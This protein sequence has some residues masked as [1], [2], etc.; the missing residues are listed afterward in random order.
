MEQ[1]CQ[2]TVHKT[3]RELLSLA[4]QCNSMNDGS[5][6][7]LDSSDSFSITIQIQIRKRCEL[8]DARNTSD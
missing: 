7:H 5:A 8:P 4:L 1:L 6:C 2:P 3:A